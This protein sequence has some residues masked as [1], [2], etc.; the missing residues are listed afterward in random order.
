M[1]ENLIFQKN[2]ENWDLGRVLFP[3]STAVSLCWRHSSFYHDERPLAEQAAVY[4]ILFTVYEYVN[5]NKQG[6]TILASAPSG[7]C[8]LIFIMTIL[9]TT[10][11]SRSRK[12]SPFCSTSSKWK[13]HSKK[14]FRGLIQ[15]EH[16]VPAYYRFWGEIV[17][18]QE[19]WG[20]N[21]FF[22]T[23]HVIFSS[24]DR[25]FTGVWLLQDSCSKLLG[26]SWKIF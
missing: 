15:E 24:S 3:A 13:G 4:P 18:L 14:K 26:Q 2:V 6:C 11:F 16:H 8:S 22:L 7:D 23:S 1:W 19:I 20:Q 9:F 5:T 25:S 10:L 12:G 17:H 21:I